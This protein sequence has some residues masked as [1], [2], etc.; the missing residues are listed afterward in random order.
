[1]ET[2]HNIEIVPYWE[3][4]RAIKDKYEYEMKK[5]L[6]KSTI[7]HVKREVF[8]EYWEPI[9]QNIV[10]R[11]FRRY[12]AHEKCVKK[13]K[14]DDKNKRMNKEKKQETKNKKREQKQTKQ[15]FK[16]K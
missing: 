1:M 14:Y 12:I 6:K 10:K 13:R 16:N 2:R 4:W 9:L 5:Q 7:K 11:N 8:F 15:R 3:I